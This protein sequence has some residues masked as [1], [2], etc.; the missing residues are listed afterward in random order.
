MSVVFIG[1]NIYFI[2]EDIYWLLLLPVLILLIALFL[3]SL[4]H[5]LLLIAFLTPL[6]Y[7]VILGNGSFGLSI[8]TEPLLIGVSVLFFLRLVSRY[9]YDLRLIKHPLSVLILCYLMWM[10]VTSISSE[11]PL[12][13]FKYWISKVWFI[14]PFYFVSMQIFKQMNNIR[15]FS[16][17]Y[18]LSFLAIIAYTI[19]RHSQ[20]GF[21][22]EAG[23]W[24]MSP[25]YNDHTAYGAM[26]AF[27]IPVLFGFFRYQKYSKILRIISFAVGAIFLLALFL[28]FSRAAWLSMMVAVGSG[29]LIVFRIKFKW[30]ASIAI[31]GVGSFFVFQNEIVHQLEKNTNESSENYIEHLR[32]IY[33]ISSDASNLE[34]I[35]RWQSALRLFKERPVVG[36]GPGTYQFVYAPKQNSREKT[37]ISTNAGDMGNA[38]SEY[39]GPLAETGILGFI[40]IVLI[41]ILA[42][43]KGIKVYRQTDISE[44]RMLSLSTVL[45]LI[46][47]FT[48][49]LINNF[50]D[51]DKAAI[52]VWAFMAM[53]VAMEVYHLKD[54]TS[55]GAKN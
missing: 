47:Y 4:D 34:R 10:F 53:I 54:K 32:S 29:L 25:F 49:G 52:P 35:N 1:A 9:T 38:H 26:L 16:Q 14:I 48:H 33:N 42:L 40:L 28:S 37:I 5:V 21:S 20:Y 31:I 39:L 51:S 2:I 41:F 7:N 6:S 30:I 13:S 12:V 24:V 45:A 19:F 11:I 18:I 27:F 3:V 44:I 15:L 43:Y 17:L 22:E 46:T 50:L 55:K 23:H 8:L 36:W